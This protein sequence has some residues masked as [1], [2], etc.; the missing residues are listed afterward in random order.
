MNNIR[1]YT[2]DGCPY[3]TELKEL[4]ETDKIPFVEVNVSR[5]ENKEEFEKLHA[6]TKSDDVPIVKVGN[7]ILVPG[8]SFQSI[9]EAHQLTKKFL[10]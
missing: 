1:I 9:Q 10:V 2:V 4:L 7:N 5:P 8:T 6:V 3:C